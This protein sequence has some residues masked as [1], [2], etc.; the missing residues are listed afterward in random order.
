MTPMESNQHVTPCNDVREVMQR[1]IAASVLQVRFSSMHRT[2]NLISTSGVC[3]L[4][5]CDST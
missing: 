3:L 2:L 5:G 1:Q 4:I